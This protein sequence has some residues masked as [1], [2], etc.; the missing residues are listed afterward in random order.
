M[1]PTLPWTKL[2]VTIAVL[3]AISF[4]LTCY[5]IWMF[6][7]ID[8]NIENSTGEYDQAAEVGKFF[9]GFFSIVLSFVSG[10]FTLVFGIIYIF[11]MRNLKKHSTK[12]KH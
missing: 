3:G 2:R 5:G 1:K 11:I 8:N 4:L 6:V 10:I 12:T 9:I 7:T